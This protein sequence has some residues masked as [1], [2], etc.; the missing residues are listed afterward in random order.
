MLCK[1]F[2]EES[3][4]SLTTEEIFN[5]SRLWK[6]EGNETIDDAKQML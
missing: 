4:V 2:A 5:L 3:E 1:K 6:F